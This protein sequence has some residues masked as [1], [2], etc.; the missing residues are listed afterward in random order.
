MATICGL[1]DTPR[2]HFQSTSMGI[3]WGNVRCG[4]LGGVKRRGGRRLLGVCFMVDKYCSAD[5]TVV[6]RSR[7]LS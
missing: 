5:P 4:R 6:R 2:F 1:V 3:P 7:R